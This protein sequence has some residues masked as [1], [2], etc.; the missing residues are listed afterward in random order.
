[1]TSSLFVREIN[2][3]LIKI[4][5]FVMIQL[6]IDDVDAIKQLITTCV[7]TKVHFVNDLK[8]NIFIDVDVL[9]S[10]RM[11][12]N[13]ERYIFT[14]DNCENIKIIIDSINRVKSHVK[15]IVRIRKTFI[16]Q[17]DELT[18]MSMTHR[19][20]LSNDKNFLFEFQ[21]VEHL[22]HD[23]DV[24]A[25]IIDVLLF[26]VQ[27]YNTTNSSIVLSRRVKLNFVI[28][29]NQ[30][31]CYMISSKNFFKTI[32][33]WMSNRV[34]RSWKIKLT[35]IVVTII[36]V[37]YIVIIINTSNTLNNVANFI[38]SSIS[39]IDANLKH[40]YSNDVIIYDQ[41][42]TIETIST[43]IVEY[44]NLFIDKN[45]INDILEQKWMLIN[46]KFN[47]VIK[48]IKIYSLNQRNREI[49]DITFD[50]LHA[51]K[52]MHFI[53]QFTSFNYSIFVV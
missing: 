20:N 41:S 13:F 3:K 24:F 14:I 17:F 7:T 45:I 22:R 33:D 10:Q 40:V 43:L 39:R 4:N 23:D 11:S 42:K 36:V 38:I 28:K 31:K 48:S 49:V 18:Y 53:N 1:M 44:Q 8:I 15:R 9:T 6:Y 32:C 30:Q 25:H 51:Q 21:C 37:A 16:V 29:Y 12:L 19:D 46:F 35:T 47:V 2:D 5:N 52:K 50:K 27:I 26:F 34:T